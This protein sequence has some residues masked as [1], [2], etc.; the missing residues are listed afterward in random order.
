MLKPQGLRL[1]AK[2]R[3]IVLLGLVFAALY[4]TLLTSSKE[5][6]RVVP[7]AKDPVPEEEQKPLTEEEKKEALKK[8][9]GD[10]LRSNF[11]QESEALGE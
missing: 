10:W 11:T 1:L 8:Q 9:K 7:W 2:P 5:G 3:N 4:W 6:Y